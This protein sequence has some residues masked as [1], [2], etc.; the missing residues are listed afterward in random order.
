[1]PWWS[2]YDA[3]ERRPKSYAYVNVFTLVVSAYIIAVCHH[4]SYNKAFSTL[5]VI[6]F[7]CLDRFYIQIILLHSDLLV[8]YSLYLVEIS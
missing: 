4:T 8:L 5:S 6:L 2:K 1:M 3:I 7:E